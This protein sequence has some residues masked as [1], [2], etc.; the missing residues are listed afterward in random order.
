MG[1]MLRLT[2]FWSQFSMAFE[3]W[4]RPTGRPRHSPKRTRRGV[5]R[6]KRRRRPVPR[7]PSGGSADS[8]SDVAARLCC[9]GCCNGPRRLLS[10][11]RRRSG[12]VAPVMAG[13]RLPYR[14]RRRPSLGG[15]GYYVG[16][17]PDH[18]LLDGILEDDV[19]LDLALAEVSSEIWSP[20]ALC[21]VNPVLRHLERAGAG[22]RRAEQL[23]RS[24]SAS[25]SAPPGRSPAAAQ[26]GGPPPRLAQCVAR[27]SPATYSMSLWAISCKCVHPAPAATGEFPVA[28]EARP[29][30][31]D[32][33]PPGEDAR[34][35]HGG[36][37][38][39]RHGYRPYPAVG[40]FG[41]DTARPASPRPARCLVRVLSRTR[42]KT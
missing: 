3:I 36:A 17:D 14:V 23:H 22:K 12:R 33:T 13:P 19:S 10:L 30:F 26:P 8:L 2:S 37:Q 15:A 35:G 31:R 9:H 21:D 16:V 5:P 28:R 41:P 11:S 34:I 32:R 24:G 18:R 42:S 6:K 29:Q 4:P 40:G 39:R 25:S 1:A 38:V 20:S 27:V 7:S